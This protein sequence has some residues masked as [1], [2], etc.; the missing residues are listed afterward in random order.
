M[1]TLLIILINKID[2]SNIHLIYSEFIESKEKA[3]E[4]EFYHLKNFLKDLSH[5]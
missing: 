4:F 1:Q 3:N 2:K 5:K